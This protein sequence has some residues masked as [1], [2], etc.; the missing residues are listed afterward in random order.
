MG[1]S[2]AVGGLA[3]QDGVDVNAEMLPTDFEAAK[4]EHEWPYCSFD[5]RY[6]DR[7]LHLATRCKD[8]ET[9]ETLL[10]HRADPSM[11]NDSS[12][13]PLDIAQGRGQRWDHAFLTPADFGGDATRIVQL[14][15]RAACT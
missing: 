9:I 5:G 10:R 7:A 14:L 4:T 2:A 13:T 15:Q 6:E 8:E 11:R 12:E 3:S 1:N